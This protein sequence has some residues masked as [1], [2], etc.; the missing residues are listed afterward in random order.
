MAE[1]TYVMKS[2]YRYSRVQIR[3]ELGTVLRLVALEV[4]DEEEVLAALDLMAE[5]NVDFDDAYLAMWASRRGEGVAS[6]DRDFARLP[7]AWHQV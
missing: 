1:V 6:F 2:L 5:Q 4:L 7:V 3:Q